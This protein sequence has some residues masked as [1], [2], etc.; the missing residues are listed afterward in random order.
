MAVLLFLGAILNILILVRKSKGPETH[1]PIVILPIISLALCWSLKSTLHFSY[2]VQR[3]IDV[4]LLHCV[5]HLTIRH[6]YHFLLRRHQSN[7]LNSMSHGWREMN[8]FM[9]SCCGRS[10]RLFDV[11]HNL[12]YHV[13][14][15]VQALSLPKIISI[16]GGLCSYCH[17]RMKN[18]MQSLLM[19]RDKIVVICIQISHNLLRGTSFVFFGGGKLTARRRA[20]HEFIPKDD[21]SAQR[22]T[23]STVSLISKSRR[24][25]QH[26]ILCEPQKQP[27]PRIVLEDGQEE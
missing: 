13:I 11:N 26:R 2:V 17:P 18:V 10:S 12:H 25:V 14:I 23:S 5:C 1:F 15:S 9:M 24:S 7:G 19:K 8:S 4:S 20:P 6:I 3:R 27:T 21:S 16:G 22:T